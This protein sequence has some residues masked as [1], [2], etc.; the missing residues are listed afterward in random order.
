MYGRTVHGWLVWKSI[1]PWDLSE[2]FE[3][4]GVTCHLADAWW[5]TQQL[6]S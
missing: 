6:T 5:K 2:G 4:E 3:E 1:H